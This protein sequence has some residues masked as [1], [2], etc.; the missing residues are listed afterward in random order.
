VNYGS[1]TVRKYTNGN[2]SKDYEEYTFNQFDSNTIVAD[3]VDTYYYDIIPAIGGSHESRTLKIKD[4]T[5]QIGQLK[6]FR[7]YS[8]DGALIFSKDISYTSEV[9]NLKKQGRLEEVHHEHRIVDPQATGDNISLATVSV[10]SRFPSV[11]I[12]SSSTD[13]KR[14]ITS[15]SENLAFDFFTGNPT[16]VLS[17]DG[18]GNS[19][20]SET[21][22][23]YS[24]A[25]YSGM[26]SDQ[27]NN[28]VVGMGLK[29]R[30]PKNKNMLTQSAG[31]LTYKVN[32]NYKSNPVDANK[33]SL[34]S[35]TAQTWS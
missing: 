15:S 33:I 31:S 35:A 16:K 25:E 11:A 3:P 2:E 28:S 6:S 7:K 29:V 10:K 1:C 18:Y 12:S 27:V 19:Y 8:V 4:F 21:V 26:T 20:V 9:S 34:V 17:T 32:S 23:A 5:S 14:L 24:I 13:F 22:P 30:N